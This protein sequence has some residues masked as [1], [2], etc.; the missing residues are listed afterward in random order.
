MTRTISRRVVCP[1]ERR[2][3]ESCRAAKQGW[4]CKA[5]TRTCI[6]ALWLTITRKHV[7]HSSVDC[8]RSCSSQAAYLTRYRHHHVQTNR[9]LSM[10]NI[11]LIRTMLRYLYNTTNTKL[12]SVPL[13]THTVSLWSRTSALVDVHVTRCVLAELAR[14]PVAQRGWLAAAL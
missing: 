6:T 1:L 4:D 7:Q 2:S 11:P 10:N 14:R 3:I 5:C 12:A 9:F 13:S 8:V